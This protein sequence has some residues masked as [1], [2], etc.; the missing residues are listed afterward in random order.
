MVKTPVIKEDGQSLMVP[1]DKMI[2]K[3]I[4]LT[5]TQAKKLV[6]REMTEKQKAHVQKMVEANRLKWEAKKK[7]K[8]EVSRAKQEQEEETKTRVIVKPKRMYNR[9]PKAQHHPTDDQID[10][11][12]E[13]IFQ[14]SKKK[15]KQVSESEP[16][17][18]PESESESESEEEIQKVAKP[19]RSK[20]TINKVEKKLEALKKIDET[21]NQIQP[22]NKYLSLLRNRF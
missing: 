6:K 2:E 18:E 1:D 12:D 8:E 15:L 13:V 4:E 16:E 10:S 19:K 9:Q 14:R 7:A 11:E 21:L 22:T 20:K 5:Y 3:P 17:S